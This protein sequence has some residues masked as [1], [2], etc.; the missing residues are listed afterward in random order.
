[1]SAIHISKPRTLFWQQ[2]VD[3][4]QHVNQSKVQ[5]CQE[6]DLICYQFI[7]GHSKLSSEHYDYAA[8]GRVVHKL[9]N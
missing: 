9:I 7:F 2:H 8:P 5:R 4:Y 6:Q 1:V 3:S